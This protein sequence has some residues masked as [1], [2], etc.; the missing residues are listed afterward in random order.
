[1]EAALGILRGPGS[2]PSQ[3]AAALGPT[4]LPGP[5]L[6]LEMGGWGGRGSADRVLAWERG[7][8][9]GSRAESPFHSLSSRLKDLWAVSAARVPAV[10]GH[11]DLPAERPEVREALQES[12]LGFWGFRGGGPCNLCSVLS[13]PGPG[14]GLAGGSRCLKAALHGEHAPQQLGRQHGVLRLRSFPLRTD[15]ILGC[16][17]CIHYPAALIKCSDAHS[18]AIGTTQKELSCP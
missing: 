12:L 2:P 5:C 14:P 10:W 15:L 18:A 9:P 6:R 8:V 17:P 13:R 3:P 4:A 1:M 11:R 7:C 16:E